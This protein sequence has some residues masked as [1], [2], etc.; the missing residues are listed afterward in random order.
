MCQ[1]GPDRFGEARESSDN[2]K[3]FLAVA[4]GVVGIETAMPSGMFWI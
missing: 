3:V 4:R 2:R 1:H